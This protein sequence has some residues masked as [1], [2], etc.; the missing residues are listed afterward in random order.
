MYDDGDED[1][2][3]VNITIE[4]AKIVRRN[5][6]HLGLVVTLD[7]PMELEQ[8]EVFDEELLYFDKSAASY[9]D[10]DKQL[11]E[12]NILGY[13]EEVGVT[14]LIDGT[15][16]DLIDSV[17]VIGKKKVKYPR[18]KWLKMFEDSGMYDGD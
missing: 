9:E 18:K 1:R 16:M 15:S 11:T 5:Q 4:A 7:G 14:I 10:V 17:T 13:L 6:E 2:E 12:D 8:E 3:R